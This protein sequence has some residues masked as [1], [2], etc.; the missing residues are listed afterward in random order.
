MAQY[1]S[2]PVKAGWILDELNEAGNVVKSIFTQDSKTQ[3][4]A[5]L[6]IEEGEFCLLVSGL[7]PDEPAFSYEAEKKGKEHVMSQFVL[8]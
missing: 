2:Y 1:N 4:E 6:S 8:N 3:D 7:H 5:L